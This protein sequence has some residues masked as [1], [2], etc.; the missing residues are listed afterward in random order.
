MKIQKKPLSAN[1][2]YPAA[3]LINFILF[4]V[5]LYIGLSTNSIGIYSD[6]V[7]NLFDALSVFLAFVCIYAVSREKDFASRGTAAKTEQLCS[8]I[9]A[10]A[11]AAAGFGFAYSSLE[12]LMYPTPVWFSPLYL[13]VLLGT[14]AVKLG[15]F[16]F[17][18]FAVKTNA[19]PVISVMKTDSILDCCI[20]LVTALTLFV[21][22]RG[23][24]SVD[25]FAGLAISAVIIVSAVR[26][27][28][29]SGASLINHIPREKR[30]EFYNALYEIIQE[31]KISGIKFTNE[32]G[33]ITAFVSC[34]GSVSDVPSISEISGIKTIIYK[35][36]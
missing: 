10:I 30:N 11:V 19:S 23:T 3:G 26:S 16:V 4:G 5:K 29:S 6:S 2:V 36:G 32:N 17:L 12:R 21:S 20:T 18:A 1:M 34:D 35:E 7:N 14:A 25:A 15:M 24:Y 13:G 31:E 22:A 27:I 28:I 8:F 9:M 33:V